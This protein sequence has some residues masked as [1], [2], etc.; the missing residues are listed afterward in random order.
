MP[1]FKVPGDLPVILG[2]GNVETHG[3]DILD[4][5]GAQLFGGSAPPSPRLG[6][7]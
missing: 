2:A 3:F 5:F 6:C 7:R 1:R 4:A